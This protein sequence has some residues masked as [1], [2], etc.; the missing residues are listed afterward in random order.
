MMPPSTR[1][2]LCCFV[3]KI[4][5]QQINKLRKTH[6]KFSLYKRTS[7]AYM[8]F[9]YTLLLQQQRY[10][11]SNE[12]THI[13]LF[14][15]MMYKVWKRKGARKHFSTKKRK[16]LRHNFTSERPHE[17]VLC[18]KHDTVVVFIHFILISYVNTCSSFYTIKILKIIKNKIFIFQL[19]VFSMV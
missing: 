12:G 13:F 5:Q 16:L 14:L 7:H 3:C 11:Q 15:V 17:N 19:I 9:F 1:Y 4:L 10:Q 8:N 18:V 2:K 6:K